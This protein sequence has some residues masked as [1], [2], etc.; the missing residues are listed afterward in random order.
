MNDKERVGMVDGADVPA[1]V[2]TEASMHTDL[3]ERLKKEN[4]ELRAGKAISDA[5]LAHYEDQQRTRLASYAG[6]AAYFFKDFVTGEAN[7]DAEALAEIAPLCT[8]ADE[9]A[10]KKNV[11]EQGSL[12]RATYVASKGIKRL[13]DQASKNGELEASLKETMAA[14]EDLKEQLSK[15]K[16]DYDGATTLAE[17]RQQG[18]KAMEEELVRLGGNQAKFDFSKLTSREAEPPPAE[19]H[20]AA[21]GVGSELTAV[22]ASA[23]ATASAPPPQEDLMATLLRR[24][25][26]GGRI[27]NSG[28]SHAT[29][30]NNG[31][32]DIASMIRAA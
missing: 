1:A 9:F 10:Q 12:A 15:M 32:T 29:L 13:R 8:W 20:V 2:S 30:G 4:E 28:T 5:S 26:A 24:S 11:M 25:T 3:L 22:K 21:A 17:E 14:N 23:S 27:M 6:E 31:D 18:L 16:R 19:P 7:G